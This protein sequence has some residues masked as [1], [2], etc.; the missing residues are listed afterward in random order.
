MRGAD[1]AHL[2]PKPGYSAGLRYEFCLG[3][4]G[5]VDRLIVAA[6]LALRFRVIDAA[7]CFRRCMFYRI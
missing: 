4:A 6:M 2:W 3:L 7:R 1:G 5:Y